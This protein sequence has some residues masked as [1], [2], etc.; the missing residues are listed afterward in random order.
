MKLKSF[1]AAFQAHSAPADKWALGIADHL[2]WGNYYTDKNLGLTSS[3]SLQVVPNLPRSFPSS[4]KLTFECILQASSLNVNF[5]TVFPSNP[6]PNPA[7]FLLWPQLATTICWL[8]FFFSGYS[9]SAA[10]LQKSSSSC[11]LLLKDKW[12]KGLNSPASQSHDLGK[13][14]VRQSGTSAKRV[15]TCS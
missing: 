12:L 14:E 7:E 6:Q 11:R 3:W 13:D 1:L 4:Q 8:V 15:F 2:Q 5:F 10:S 9:C